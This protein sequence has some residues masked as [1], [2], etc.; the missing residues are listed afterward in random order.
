MT[1][2]LITYLK[3]KYAK[4]ERIV[5]QYAHALKNKAND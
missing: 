4:A 2:G 3:R 5:K 1:P